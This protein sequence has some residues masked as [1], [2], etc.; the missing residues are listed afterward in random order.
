MATPGGQV[1]AAG[2]VPVVR[3]DILAYPSP[4]TTRFLVLVG[5]LLTAGL[6][7]GT[8]VH[9]GSAAGD[10]W[11]RTVAACSQQP[12]ASS[13]LGNDPRAALR[14]QDAFAE[15]TAPAERTRAGYAIAG[16]LIAGCGGIM[17]LFVSP[18]LV[19][20]RRRLRIPGP[21]LDPAVRRFRELTAD[22]RL[23]RAPELV[24]G[25]A[26]QRDAFSYG[27]PGRYRVALP[28]AIA[29][30]WADPARFDPV[31]RHELAHVAHR[32]IALAW[33]TRS[34]WYALVPL[35]V[36]PVVLALARADFSL[37]PDYVWRALLLA[38]V[39][40]L[41]STATLRSR[42]HDA[43]LR[44]ARFAGDEESL[45]ALLR[46]ARPQPTVGLRRLLAYH[47]NPARRVEVLDRPGQA[48]TVTFVDGL[49]AAYL[50]AL[51]SPL[52]VGVI[53]ALL[54]GT[55]QVSLAEVAADLLVGPLIGI[56]VGLGLWRQILVRRVVGGTR[57]AITAVALGVGTGMVLGQVVSLG[58]A[59]T[60]TLGGLDNP[61][62]LLVTGVLA[63]GATVVMA[64]LGEL[65]GDA[66]PRIRSARGSWMPAALLGGVLFAAVLWAAATL[67]NVL[68][69]GGWTLAG[70]ALIAVLGTAPPATAALIL[71]GGAGWALHADPAHCVVGAAVV[72]RERTAA[73]VAE[74]C[75][76]TA[77]PCTGHR[78]GSW[79]RGGGDDCD[80]PRERGGGDRA[81]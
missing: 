21:R 57:P 68:D 41:V 31:V 5:A 19:E 37:V 36:L 33:L 54:T 38:S 28:P 81:R 1:G 7:V 43:D 66:A 51:S 40:M 64:G 13:Q 59:G 18:V 45:A 79:P 48:T 32:D 72:T 61:G 25:P 15:C 70:A 44:A 2:D 50:A 22:A 53:S 46:S 29:V 78:R 8:W 77:S 14:A 10:T 47:P 42:E 12:A 56:T 6:F 73:A 26:T 62:W 30:H 4:T 27:A 17:V 16:A 69:W 23:S 9:N 55:G 60:G 71:A 65:W 67:Q 35:L 80:L 3:P 11:A 39:V 75:R 24:V 63:M 76:S 74:P 52:L 20:R 49:A 34:I 58:Q